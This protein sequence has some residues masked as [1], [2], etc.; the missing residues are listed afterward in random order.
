MQLYDPDP[1]SGI[2]DFRSSIKTIAILAIVMG[3]YAYIRLATNGMRVLFGIL[4]LFMILQVVTLIFHYKEISLPNL[5]F[6]VISIFV[7]LSILVGPYKFSTSSPSALLIAALMYRPEHLRRGNWLVGLII[8]VAI[9]VVA[10]PVTCGLVVETALIE[11]LSW[12]FLFLV[13]LLW[14]LCSDF[15]ASVIEWLRD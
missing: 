7:T 8:S 14:I 4:V 13:I 3:L 5:A 6:E 11:D 15:S 10:L 12:I 2:S 9:A 1:E